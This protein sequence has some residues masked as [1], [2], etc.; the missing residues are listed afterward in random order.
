M[1]KNTPKLLFFPVIFLCL[2]QTSFISSCSQDEDLI[3]LVGLEDP[4][5][6]TVDG[7][8]GDND[9]SNDQ[10]TPDL[11][12]TDNG[13]DF[14]SSDGLKISDVPCAFSL[15]I[16]ESNST[17][18][19]DCLLDLE[20]KAID[21]PTG[22]TLVYKGGEITNGTLNFTEGNI[23]G[24]LLN[25]SLAIEG[26]AKLID[27]S[28]QFYPERWG[29]VEGE[30]TDVKAKANRDNL[31]K[32]M[33]L[34]KF[35]GG[36]IFEI[37][38]LDAY[39]DVQ[40]Y[41]ANPKYQAQ[42]SIL[43]PNDNFH[44]KMSDDTYL[45]VQPNGAPAYNLMT[46]YEGTNIKISGGNLIGDRWKHDYSPVNDTEGRERNSH[47]WGHILKIQ[48]GKNV[49][50]DGVNISN[51]T[52]DGFGVHGSDIR[53]ADGS[54][55]SSV[56]SEN[57]VI[58]NSSIENARRNGMSILDGNGIRV[59][60]CKVFNTGLGKENPE[61]VY[62]SDGTWPRYGISFE[63]Y[64]E[65]TSSGELREYN[66]IENVTLKG[67]RFE[68]NY[69]G[70]IVL[71]T[72]S[73]I[74]IDNNFF[75]SKIA[76][77]AAHSVTI[78]NNNFKARLDSNG[79]PYNYALNLQSNISEWDGE[80]TYNY[81]I[82]GNTIEGY[83]NG[84]ILGGKDYKVYGNLFLN[85]KNSLGFENID[86]GEFYDNEF[87]SDLPYSIA[88]FSRGAQLKNVKVRNEIIQVEYRP[89][90]FRSVEGLISSLEFTGCEMISKTNKS[91]FIENSSN[92]KI[93]NNYINSEFTVN[94]S[95]NIVISD[96]RS[97]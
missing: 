61:G 26:N 92:I 6:E 58:R 97:D 95:S 89:I 52:G 53:N 27:P 1:Q 7:S 37:D 73:N 28:F 2:I 81:S 39:F 41:L 51:S 79:E 96:N 30:T 69:A 90:N 72:C 45:R 63:A 74:V 22:V 21:L 16:L 36:D 47:G 4:D 12:E 8:D 23:S 70:D 83:G 17:L 77:I 40:I 33:T 94:N 18:E 80:F 54:P 71:Y 65:R 78:S 82:Y 11:G 60:N 5:D 34:V 91:N 20:G 84:M 9:G 35:L 56:I 13:P 64:R 68:N 67:N 57:V 93:T 66:R 55:G 38:K 24:N 44:L 59:E 46:V 43:L 76:N 32:A 15:S 88:Y 75:D 42:E 49:I 14:D 85:N 48:G 19:I 29:I 31:R 50:V 62:S 3:D 25:N 10:E 86:S 87:Y